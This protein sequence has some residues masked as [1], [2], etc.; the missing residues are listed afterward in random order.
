M[1]RYKIEKFDD[2]TTLEPNVKSSDAIDAES[3]QDCHCGKNAE[4]GCEKES[5]KIKKI[6]IIYGTTTGMS[7]DFAWKLAKEAEEEGFEFDV[8]NV[9]NIEAEEFL[10]QEASNSK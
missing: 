1:Y 9:A 4:E 2:E 5:K 8:N 7:K 6:S 3:C 10:P